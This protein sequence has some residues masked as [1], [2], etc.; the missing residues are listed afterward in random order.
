MTDLPIIATRVHQEHRI[1][2]SQSASRI[3]AADL[4]GTRGDE[5][6]KRGA[7]GIAGVMVRWGIDPRDR[8][9]GHHAHG[10]PEQQSG[11]AFVGSIHGVGMAFEKD[12]WVAAG[13]QEYFGILAVLHCEPWAVRHRVKGDTSLT[14][15]PGRLRVTAHSES[16]K[17]HGTLSNHSGRKKLIR[18]P[19]FLY[20]TDHRISATSERTTRGIRDAVGRRSPPR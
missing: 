20:F 7:M 16:R 14:K 10:D 13:R 15:T 3:D 5:T 2:L 8:N 6:D 4:G 1:I 19:C 18:H 11:N 9:H 12:R 17:S